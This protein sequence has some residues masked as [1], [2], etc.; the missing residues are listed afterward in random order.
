ML[1]LASRGMVPGLGL[2]PPC[3]L[4]LLRREALVLAGHGVVCA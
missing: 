4:S 3:S 1:L 2:L